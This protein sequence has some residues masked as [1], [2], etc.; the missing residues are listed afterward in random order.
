[1]LKEQSIMYSGLNN[2]A[3]DINV[4][5][6]ISDTRKRLYNEGKLDHSRKHL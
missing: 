1:M 2:P 4:R 6:K 3:C 5:K